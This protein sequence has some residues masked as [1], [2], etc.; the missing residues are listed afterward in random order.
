VGIDD[1]NALDSDD[2]CVAVWENVL[3]GSAP[4]VATATGNNIEYVARLAGQ[5]C[6][7]TY[8]GQGNDDSIV[9]DASNGTVVTNYTPPTP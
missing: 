4:R 9:Y 6:T 2:D 3:Q 8:R 5:V 7:Y 1:G